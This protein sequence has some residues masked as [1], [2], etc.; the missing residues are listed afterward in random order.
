MDLSLTISVMPKLIALR[1]G[2]TIAKSKNLHNITVETD[3]SVLL[4]MLMI[5]YPSYH[6]LL[7]ECRLLMEEI[8]TAIPTKI[9][10]EQNT[11]ADALPKE[12]AKTEELEPK[13]A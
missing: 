11:V 8:H 9:Y 5:D 1:Y 2:L 4:Y 10:K 3:S 6:N 12:G 7:S 13:L